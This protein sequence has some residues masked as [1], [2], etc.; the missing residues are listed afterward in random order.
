[1]YSI[2]GVQVQASE[3]SIRT[4][5]VCAM[6]FIG[7]L[8]TGICDFFFLPFFH[9][10]FSQFLTHTHN[11]A[12][13]PWGGRW[14]HYHYFDMQPP[15]HHIQHSTSICAQNNRVYK[16]ALSGPEAAPLVAFLIGGFHSAA[17]GVWRGEGTTLRKV[18]RAE[19][20]IESTK[21]KEKPSSSP[22][23]IVRVGW[24]HLTTGA[25]RLSPWWA[26]SPG[27][28]LLLLLLQAHTL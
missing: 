23:A 6:Q 3:V 4:F 2:F 25:R 16:S 9:Y 20:E 26:L 5:D 19:A 24:E 21:V 8:V 11:R 17:P 10:L 14:P 13:W 28:G 27:L 15:A 7:Y 12:E 22:R 18:W 1:M